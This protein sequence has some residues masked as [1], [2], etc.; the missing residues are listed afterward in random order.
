MPAVACPQIRDE[1]SRLGYRCIDNALRQDGPDINLGLRI[2]LNQ[3]VEPGWVISEGSGNPR[4]LASPPPNDT[5]VVRADERI[6]L[7]TNP[8]ARPVRAVGRPRS[9]RGAPAYRAGPAARLRRQ[10]VQHG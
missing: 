7:H 5:V 2:S 1:Q 8:A 3:E 9:R 10:P 4:S 6:A